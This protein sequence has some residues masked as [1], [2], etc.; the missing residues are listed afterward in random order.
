M[1]S[2]ILVNVSRRSSPGVS[3]TLCLVAGH[4]AEGTQFCGRFGA[5]ICCFSSDQKDKDQRGPYLG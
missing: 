1:T 3:A 4:C 2:D 5:A